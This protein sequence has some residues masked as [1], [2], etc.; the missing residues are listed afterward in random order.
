MELQTLHE[1]VVVAR[2][3]LCG[4]YAES[5]GPVSHTGIGY[6]LY[7]TILYYI[8]YKSDLHNNTTVVLYPDPTTSMYKHFIYNTSASNRAGLF[9]YFLQYITM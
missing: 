9:R 8:L 3:C 2:V 1:P 6:K 7:Y 4:T 5:D